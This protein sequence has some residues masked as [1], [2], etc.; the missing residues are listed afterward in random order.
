MKSLDWYRS[1]SF[2]FIF[3]VYQK[4]EKGKSFLRVTS[5]LLKGS[6]VELCRLSDALIVRS[7][8]LKILDEGPV[9]PEEF[10]LIS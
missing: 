1:K 9:L 3:I 5:L 10:L 4:E 8:I 6:F 2:I 7:F